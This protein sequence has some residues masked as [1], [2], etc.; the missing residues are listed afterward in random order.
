[1]EIKLKIRPCIT[2]L[3]EVN[4]FERY[5]LL[6]YSNEKQI[7]VSSEIYFFNKDRMNKYGG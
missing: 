4:F 3:G 2:W 5:N 1:M 6:F 7:Y